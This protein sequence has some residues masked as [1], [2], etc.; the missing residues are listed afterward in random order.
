[1]KVLMQFARTTRH[2]D[3][4]NVPTARELAHNDA[5]RSLIELGELPYTLA[6]PFAAPP[7][8][9]AERAKALQ[10]AFVAVHKDPQLIDE[11]A[12]L[13]IDITPIGGDEVA[14]H[15]ERIS[16]A[17]PDQLDYIRK[18]LAENKGG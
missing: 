11:A 7:G 9:P 4:P 18:L 10:D 15:I 14:A 2:P 12:R 17:P 6:R 3:L 1:M 5:A 13:Q 8:I 16:K